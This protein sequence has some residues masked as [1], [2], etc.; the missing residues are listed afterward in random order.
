MTSWSISARRGRLIRIAATAVT[1]VGLSLAAGCSN[2]DMSNMPMG[3]SSP[4]QAASSSSATAQFNDADVT[5]A[6]MMI[7]HH[8]QAEE[9]RDIILAKDGVDPQVVTLAEQIKQA[10]QP[11]I[12]TMTGWLESWGQPVDGG[13]GGM[14]GLDDGGDS[15]MMSDE[16]MQQLR[17]ADAATGQRQFLEGM[18]AHHR[19]AVAMAQD[20]IDNGSNPDAIKLAETI[21]ETQNEEIATMEKLLQQI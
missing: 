18:M 10:Q 2:D 21:V 17:D 3:S 8:Q 15:G 20:E 12:D 5:F 4:S 1:V 11:E 19:G 14:G 13:M 7:P 9:M 6:Q 16:D